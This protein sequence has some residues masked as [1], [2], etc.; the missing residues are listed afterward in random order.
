MRSPTD[1]Y[2]SFV[3]G[4]SAKEACESSNRRHIRVRASLEHTVLGITPLKSK[5]EG[6]LDVGSSSEDPRDPRN[7]EIKPLRAEEMEAL[8]NIQESLQEGM[9]ILF[10][11]LSLKLTI[12]NDTDMRYH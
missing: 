6:F 2:N 11:P 5:V 3:N 9:S 10:E 7:R 4:I 12:H 1:Y 8:P